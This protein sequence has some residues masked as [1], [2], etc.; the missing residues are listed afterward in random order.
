MKCFKEV[1][2]QLSDYN[3]GDQISLVAQLKNEEYPKG[4]TK[5]SLNIIAQ[6]II[7]DGGEVK[8]TKKEGKFGW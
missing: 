4:S 7:S 1:A 3:D 6:E 2:E 8:E 5:W